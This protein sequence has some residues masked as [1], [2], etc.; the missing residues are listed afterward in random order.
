MSMGFGDWQ[1]ELLQAA[2]NDAYSN[3][4]VLVA[5]SGNSPFGALDVAY[6]ARCDNV[7]A[8]GATIQE[9]TL[10]CSSQYGP[11]LDVCGTGR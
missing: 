2:I 1:V 8:V 3:G 5:S 7:I 4:A 10:W 6:P 11:S 9:D